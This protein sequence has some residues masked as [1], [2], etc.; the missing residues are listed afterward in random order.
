MKN[1]QKEYIS[2]EQAVETIE[3]IADGYI[4]NIADTSIEMAAVVNLKA[5]IIAAVLKETDTVNIDL[6]NGLVYLPSDMLNHFRKGAESD[7]EGAFLI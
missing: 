2:L 5:H 6:K 3:R 7:I 4:D 1:L